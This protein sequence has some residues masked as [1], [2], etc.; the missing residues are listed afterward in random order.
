MN[1]LQNHRI[2]RARLGR[3]ALFLL[4][5]LVLSCSVLSCGDTSTKGEVTDKYVIN[6]VLSREAASNKVFATVNM[7]QNSLPF[8]AAIVS[9]EAPTADSAL[10]VYL[11]GDAAG[12]FYKQFQPSSLRDTSYV[13][14]KAAV[15][16]F[17]FSFPLSVPDTF[18]F[19]TSGLPN[20]QVKSSTQQV[21]IL[22]THSDW[23]DGYFVVVAPA[24][25]GNNAVGYTRVL[26][27]NE[28]V[29]EGQYLMATIPNTAF[30]TTQGEFQTGEYNIWV[31]AFHDSP[32]TY[33]GLPFSLPSE[34]TQNVN[35]T[36]GG[37]TGQI[38]AMYIAQKTIVTAVAGL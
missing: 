7:T 26:H 1:Y 6:G 23:A 10:P 12:R 38:G 18:S 15:G 33:S 14:V 5:L 35:I 34:F 17:Q 2:F 21:K 29:S 32:I 20:N 13:K 11:V 24:S 37:I 9:I 3:T 8:T 27:S 28:Y 25:S 30:R 16:T 19:A 22:W 4:L 36:G 31:V